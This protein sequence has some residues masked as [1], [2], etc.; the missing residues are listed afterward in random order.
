[1]FVFKLYLYTR[2]VEKF[3]IKEIKFNTEAICSRFLDI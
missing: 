2:A 3:N 1:M